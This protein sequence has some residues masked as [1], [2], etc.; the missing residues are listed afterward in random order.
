VLAEGS[1]VATTGSEGYFP[2]FE[3]SLHYARRRAVRGLP[4]PSWR[5]MEHP[6]EP[7]SA[8]DS[9]ARLVTCHATLFV[10]W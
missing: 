10:D 5:V 4:T 9:R 6:P 3:V 1:V 7:T 8:E 2:Q